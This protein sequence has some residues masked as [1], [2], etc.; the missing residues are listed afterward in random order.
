VERPGG[1]LRSLAALLER[2]EREPFAAP[3]L[4][5]LAAELGVDGHLPSD[6]LRRLARLVDLAE[7]RRNPFFVPFA[8]LLLW[9]V[10]VSVA[11]EAW[12]ARCGAAATR[13]AAAVGEIEAL[14]GLAA[15]AWEHP[16]E[17][18]P[19]LLD[20]GPALE[21]EQLGHVLLPGD[22]VVR[23]DVSL[24]S[25]PSLLIVSGSNM[26]GKSTLLRS[27]GT[28]V[29]LAQAG[30]T[31]RARR[32]RLSPLTLGASIRINDSLHQG[33]SR[34][35][36]EITRLRQ[37]VSLADDA[38]PLLFLLDEL[39]AGTNSHDRRVGAAAVIRGLLG[40]GSIGLLTTH[41]LALAEIA[42]QLD[43][44]A[45]NVHFE[46]RLEQG[47]V[48]FDYRMRDGVVRRSNALELMRAV[49]LEV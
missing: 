34:F 9:D 21:A 12:I 30:A 15:R 29:V 11:V 7:S 39:L 47:R 10:H 3:R 37:L 49:G 28:S 33:S 35:Y 43:G 40:R 25:R 8:L 2:L 20:A 26:S 44:R 45:A 24:G 46:D 22:R 13:W 18:F 48:V 17:P 4:R 36:A 23:N 42:D 14:C 5:Q 1:E 32:L 6:Q 38:P 19:E 27:I 41:D 31:V 16:E